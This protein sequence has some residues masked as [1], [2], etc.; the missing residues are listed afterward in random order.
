MSYTAGM[1]WAWVRLGAAELHLFEKD[2][3]DPATTAAAADLEVDDADACRGPF[4]AQASRPP[5]IVGHA[6]DG[7]PKARM[8]ARYARIR[9]ALFPSFP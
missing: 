6:G 9:P 8:S 7:Q 2:D 1:G 5:V 3:H 4:A